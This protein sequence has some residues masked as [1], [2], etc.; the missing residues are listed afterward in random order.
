MGR[1]IIVRWYFETLMMSH[2]DI[3]LLI[4]VKVEI[5]E[6]IT[7]KRF[8]CVLLFSF[9]FPQIF[10]QTSYFFNGND[11]VLYTGDNFDT[12]V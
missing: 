12:L 7:T 4:L 1:R 8:N 11:F 9:I 6:P 10:L 3:I 5:N 2:L